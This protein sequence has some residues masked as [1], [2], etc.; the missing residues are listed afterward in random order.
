MTM[1][2]DTR[3]AL[4]RLAK[5]NHIKKYDGDKPWQNASKTITHQDATVLRVQ[6]IAQLK[7]LTAG[8]YG[9]NT[10][11]DNPIT[12]IKARVVAGNFDA[13]GF[14]D[15][16]CWCGFG[17]F[18]NKNNPLDNTRIVRK[19]YA[20]APETRADVVIELSPDFTKDKLQVRE[21]EGTTERTV[22]IPAFMTFA[23][24][25]DSL[26]GNSLTLP[27]VPANCNMSVVGAVVN[28]T[29][30]LDRFVKSITFINEKGEEQTL[31][32]QEGV[33]FHQELVKFNM[34]GIITSLEFKAVP[35]QHILQQVAFV[36]TV[37]QLQGGFKLGEEKQE[38]TLAG[39]IGHGLKAVSVI[40]TYRQDPGHESDRLPIKNI[41][42]EVETET[43]RPSVHKKDQTLIEELLEEIG[44]RA[45]KHGAE[46]LAEILYQKDLNGLIR[47]YQMLIAALY[48]AKRGDTDIVAKKSSLV[49][50]RLKKPQDIL[51]STAYLAVKT[52]A[53]KTEGDDGVLHKLI[54]EVQTTL[55][56]LYDETHKGEDAEPATPVNFFTVKVLDQGSEAWLSP[57][58]AGADETVVAIEF[59]SNPHAFGFATFLQQFNANIKGF[60]NDSVSSVNFDLGQ[61]MPT[62][63]PYFSA[64]KEDVAAFKASLGT[65]EGIGTS[66]F[67][68]PEYVALMDK[69]IDSELEEDVTS[70]LTEIQRQADRGHSAEDMIGLVKWV[71]KSASAVAKHY[72]KDYPDVKNALSLFEGVA[73]ELIQAYKQKKEEDNRVPSVK[74]A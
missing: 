11:T 73:N 53:L 10:S 22:S 48:H 26:K 51:K 64:S 47:P 14:F 66:P 55:G 60:F 43:T 12:P 54:G 74:V 42:V 67:V 31:E 21:P 19:S 29:D 59:N 25:V 45:A 58:K 35:N 56:T 41:K 62:N 71:V 44:T 6:S 39:L 49:Q 46:K 37:E 1:E 38:A 3:A 23:E 68:R 50:N 15:P 33:D 72:T 13:A 17:A 5:D 4:E 63:T 34:K 69:V 20:Q 61:L 52:D 40:P 36:E 7:A 70:G 28:G 9:M 8:I 57:V 16:N 30:G 65:A 32:E 2:P 27:K 24:V 18:F